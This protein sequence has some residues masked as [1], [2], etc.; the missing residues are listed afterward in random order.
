MQSIAFS[1][2]LVV[3]A[4]LALLQADELKDLSSADVS[5]NTELSK[6]TEALGEGVG[7]FAGSLMTSGSFTMVAGG[8]F[9]E[10]ELGEGVGDFAGSL[11]TS[12]SF[13]M[14]AGGGFN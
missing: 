4:S 12:G 9:N 13:T 5:S 8:G 7:D 1:M 14:V 3:L 6:D 11:M 10:E 2:V